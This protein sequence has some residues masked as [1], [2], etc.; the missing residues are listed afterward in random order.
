MRGGGIPPERTMKR[1]IRTASK[2]KS[3]EKEEAT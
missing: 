2:L 3:S 1:P